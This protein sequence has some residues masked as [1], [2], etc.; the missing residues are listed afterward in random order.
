MQ[1]ISNFRDLG[2]LIGADGRRVKEKRILR[3]G[4][5]NRTLPEDLKSLEEDYRLKAVVDLRTRDEALEKP[6]LIPEGAEYFFCPV[7][8]KLESFVP[9]D[10]ESTSLSYPTR[11]AKAIM[12][13]KVDIDQ[14]LKRSYIGFVSSSIG[15]AGYS[16]MFRILLST[17]E[18]SVYLHCS[19]G[20]DR[21]GLAALLVLSALGVDREAI[22]EDYLKTNR[23]PSVVLRMEDAERKIRAEGISDQRAI[24]QV[25][26][27]MSVSIEWLNLAI[28]TIEGLYGSLEGYLRDAM[29][30]DTRD[31]EQLREMY[32]E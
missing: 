20:K 6:D 28:Q 13:G 16:R 11:M 24:D 21:T 22:V 12:A 27:S 15:M 25:K 19:A 9:G 32:L 8:E 31:I 4:A 30:L 10:E 1:A 26:L 5:L 23:D 3:G 17:G 7:R 2:G 14:M 29:G 18:G